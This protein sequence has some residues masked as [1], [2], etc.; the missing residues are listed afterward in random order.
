MRLIYLY[1]ENPIEALR[2]KELNF[3]GH[4]EINLWEDSER[5]GER[6]EYRFRLKR[7]EC[8]DDIL[9]G[10]NAEVYGIVGNNGTGK[11]TVLD[12]IRRLHFDYESFGEEVGFAFSVWEEQ[13]QFYLCENSMRRESVPIR[14]YDDVTGE[15]IPFIHANQVKSTTSMLYYSDIVDEKYVYHQFNGSCMNEAIF[16]KF[17]N[18]STSYYLQEA[19]NTLKRLRS[20]FQNEVGRELDFI[21]EVA[22]KHEGLK[23]LYHIPNQLDMMVNLTDFKKL[24]KNLRFSLS[25]YTRDTHQVSNGALLET[26]FLT[27]AKL[28]QDE[29]EALKRM[30]VKSERNRSFFYENCSQ[31]M[32]AVLQYNGILDLIKCVMDYEYQDDGESLEDERP[33]YFEELDWIFDR[34][35]HVVPDVIRLNEMYMAVQGPGGMKMNPFDNR[36]QR[37]LEFNRLILGAFCDSEEVGDATAYCEYLQEFLSFILQ[38]TAIGEIEAS[39]SQAIVHFKVDTKASVHMKTLLT[40]YGDY[41]VWAYHSWLTFSWGMS[42]GEKSRVTL[43]ARFYDAL[44]RERV[45]DCIILLDELDYYMHPTWQQNILSEFML[46]LKTVF[47]NHRFQIIFTTHSPITLSDV[48]KENILF[49]SSET[50]KKEMEETFAANIAA[51]YLSAFS[52]DKGSIGLIGK[53]FLNKVLS[54]LGQVNKNK[55]NMREGMKERQI[56]FLR[57]FYGE[58]QEGMLDCNHEAEIRRIKRLVEYVGE[59]IFRI[60]LLQKFE[61]CSL[62]P[63]PKEDKLQQELEQLIQNYGRAELL[64]YFN[65]K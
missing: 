22:Q 35:I 8:F 3:S 32:E 48:R 15:Q 6:T 45:G 16:C 38:C 5:K 58:H 14:L 53:S 57:A 28:L 36:M 47:P 11:S 55:K 42:S 18:V 41:K 4:Y 65:R 52:M 19:S 20:H 49:L 21:R 46:F 40:L 31:I 60:K 39:Q 62:L 26:S 17:Q 7:K 54:A 24:E 9:Y 2:G 61:E 30:L 50:S 44:K 59:D 27:V 1:V 25:D 51:L 10:P 13:G 56:C 33:V 12:Y 64:E 29:Y 23:E 34:I 63:S 43:F 37:I